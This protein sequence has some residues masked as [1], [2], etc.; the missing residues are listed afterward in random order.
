MHKGDEQQ[1]PPTADPQERNERRTQPP[2]HS[3]AEPSTSYQDRSAP[4]KQPSY[5]QQRPQQQQHNE[6][7]K[8]LGKVT[9]NTSRRNGWGNL[10]YAELITKAILS[11]EDQRLTLS[12]IYDYLIRTIPYF[13]ERSSPSASAGWKNSIRH[14]LS[15]HNRFQRTHNENSSKSSW[16]SINFN[17]MSGK[18]N[19]KRGTN[20]EKKR[21]KKGE[22][23]PVSRSRTVQMSNPQRVPRNCYPPPEDI[24]IP[25][26]TQTS[27]G[28]NFGIQNQL[29]HYENNAY[30]PNSHFNNGGG[31][32]NYQQPPQ[33]PG[34]YAQQIQPPREQMPMQNHL[35]SELPG[36]RQIPMTQPGM[37]FQQQEYLQ[38]A[39][40]QNPPME[41]QYFSSAPN[42]Y[43]QEDGTFEQYPPNYCTIHGNHGFCNDCN[44][45]QPLPESNLSNVDEIRYVYGPPNNEDIANYQNYDGAIQHFAEISNADDPSTNTP[46]QDENDLPDEAGP[47]NKRPEA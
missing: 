16:W 14:N 40:L 24:V 23:N 47:S 17:E 44:E 10:S 35:I 13:A 15:L 9:K 32:M 7:N 19:R 34:I 37:P 42:I 12:E 30:Y 45:P 25:R 28:N 38:M 26:S 20:P 6:A 27:V 29:P 3:N 31:E 11:S 46:N 36:Q 5:N 2:S 33:P 4:V 43:S 21:G 8:K 1:P 18:S 39:P 41:Q 22:P